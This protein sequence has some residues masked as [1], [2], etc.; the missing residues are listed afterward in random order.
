LQPFNNPLIL[1]QMLAVADNRLSGGFPNTWYTFGAA[2][3]PLQLLDLRDNC[4][5]CGTFVLS[6]FPVGNYVGEVEVRLIARHIRWGTCAPAVRHLHSL[7]VKLVGQQLHRWWRSGGGA[8]CRWSAC[9]R[10]PRPC[11]AQSNVVAVARMRPTL[12]S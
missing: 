1:L 4:Q 2:P 8:N 12:I 11:S 10:Q 3:S 7:P 9:L 5:L 6:D